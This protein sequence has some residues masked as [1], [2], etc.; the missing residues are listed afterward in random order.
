M[1]KLLTNLKKKYIIGKAFNIARKELCGYMGIIKDELPACIDEILSAYGINGL[2]KWHMLHNGHINRTYAV[3][4][5]DGG[6]KVKRLLQQINTAV[7]KNPEELMAN[8]VTVT[9][10]L[11]NKIKREGG[12]AERE[13]LRVWPTLGG[14]SFY[15]DSSGLYWRIYNFVDNAFSYDSI[16]NDS[17]F[18]RAGEAFGKFQ[19]QL[20][21]FP[22]DKLYYT[23]PH[24]HDT[25]KRLDALRKSAEKNAVGRLR[26]VGPEIKFA[27][28]REGDTGVIVDMLERGEIPLR[29]THNDTKLNNIMFDNDTKTPVC[30]VDLDTIMPGSALYD[31]GDAIRYGANTAAEDEKDLSKVSLDMNLYEK[32]VSG[33]LGTAG[34]SLTEKEKEYLPFSAKL[35]TLECGIRFL[36]DY[37]DGDVYFSVGSPEHNL[38]RCRTQF[39][40]VADMENK[41]DDMKKITESVC[42]SLGL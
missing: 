14:G 36:T 22:I 38:D 26:D 32:Y 1:N 34:G 41:F 33:F 28:C 31:F 16:E 7:F 13:T 37:L 9:D 10:F 5:T 39:A 19:S 8:V 18:F 12:D 24:F 25:R 21:D 27:L 2:D 6:E 40:L 3:E 42:K 20:S 29:V 4:Y 17:L 35:L 15:K 23:I 30:I 11:R